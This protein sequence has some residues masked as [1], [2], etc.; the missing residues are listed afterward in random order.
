MPV[1]RSK[2]I[3][4]SAGVFLAGAVLGALLYAYAP[5]LYRTTD[6]EPPANFL[7]VTDRIHTS[8]Q[9]TEAQLGGLRRAGYDM[10]VN[11]SPP[12]VF[13]SLPREGALVARAGLDYVNIPVDWHR[14]E[15]EDFERFAHIL[16]GLRSGRILVHCQVN[17]RASLFTFLYRVIHEDADPDEAYEGV[18]AIWVPDPHWIDFARGVLARNGIDYEL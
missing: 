5:E 7:M 3:L 13:G 2:V 11:L 15:Y 12:Q 8:G 1:N 10:V 4:G 18:I 14:P 6:H 17:K 9:P 16:T